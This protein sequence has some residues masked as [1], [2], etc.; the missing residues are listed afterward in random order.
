M[1]LLDIENKRLFSENAK[2]CRHG[3][4]IICQSISKFACIFVQLEGTCPPTLEKHLHFPTVARKG[5]FTSPSAYS[6]R[7]ILLSFY[8]PASL[9]LFKIF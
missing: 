1:S 9:C 4:K 6:H 5:T 3:S 8:N 2:F 7:T